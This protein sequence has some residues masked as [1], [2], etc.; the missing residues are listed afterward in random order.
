[1]PVCMVAGMVFHFLLR[2]ILFCSCAIY[3]VEKKPLQ[4][5]SRLWLPYGCPQGYLAPVLCM[6][7]KL[8]LIVH[9][10]QMIYGGIDLTH[11]VHRNGLT[12]L[13]CELVFWGIQ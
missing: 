10:P 3:Y 2:A 12:R 1:M 9:S 8:H 4:A 6:V 7:V 13:L 5:F 11:L